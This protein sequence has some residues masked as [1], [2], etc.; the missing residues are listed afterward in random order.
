ME[1][2]AKSDILMGDFGESA[3]ATRRV[4]ESPIEVD[5]LPGPCD[6]RLLVGERTAATMHLADGGAISFAFRLVEIGRC[7]A[8]PGSNLA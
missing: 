2:F 3:T 7:P 8:P 1:G 5:H 6:R 4:G